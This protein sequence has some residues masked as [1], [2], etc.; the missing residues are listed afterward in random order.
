V[1]AG[2]GIDSSLST[3]FSMIRYN[4]DGTLDTTFGTSGRVTTDFGDSSS[5]YAMVI[6]P[7]DHK[8]VLTG[9]TYSGGKPVFGLARYNANGTLDTTFGVGGK[10]ITDVSA[11]GNDEARGVALQ[12]DGKIV[13]VGWGGSPNARL[14]VVRY[15]VNGSLDTSFNTTGKVITDVD[16]LVNGGDTQYTVSKA[17]DV[18]IQTDQ[19]IV[20]TGW[21]HGGSPQL[22]LVRYNPDGSLDTSFG[23]N[24]ITAHQ[25]EN[26]AFASAMTIQIDGKILVTG[27]CNMSSG[28]SNQFLLARYTS[29]GDL[30]TTFDTDGIVTTTFGSID[31]RAQ[32][33]ALQR[34]G[35]IVVVGYSNDGSHKHFALARYGTDGSLD[36]TFGAGG[37]MIAA[38]G[39]GDSQASAVSIQ[40]IDY[41][42][43]VAGTAVWA[44]TDFA[45]IR[46]LP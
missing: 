14:E 18:S 9:T 36:A 22:T 45:V 4:A 23:T 2:S 16:F 46:V 6:Q 44:D 15:N 26:G 38:V 19:K 39:T 43:V 10:Q 24:G 11:S 1:V 41:K 13:V 7:T 27:R 21:N 33:L 29:D 25:I 28:N 12:A 40:S 3:R 34:D 20:V 32:A 42:I 30:D 8:I 17:F 5:A 35:K 37:R 31:D